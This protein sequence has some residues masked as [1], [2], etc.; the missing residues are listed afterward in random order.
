MI[1]KAIEQ[2]LRE[3]WNDN[4]ISQSK[5]KLYLQGYDY[6][7]EN[8]NK[9]P[10]SDKYFDEPKIHFII[11]SAVDMAL[12]S[13]AEV[14]NNSYYFSALTKKPS[15][16]E[17]SIIK[18]VYDKVVAKII[19]EFQATQPIEKV[20]DD[21]NCEEDEITAVINSVTEIV[22]EEIFPET[23]S[24]IVPPTTLGNLLDHKDLLTESIEFHKYRGDSNWGMDAKIKAFDTPLTVRY[25]QELNGSAGRQILSLEDKSLIEK[26]VNKFQTSS[27]TGILFGNN[28]PNDYDI[29][30][31]VPIY[32]SINNIR[33]KG[34]IDIVAVDHTNKRI[35]LYDIKTMAD[36]VIQFPYDYRKRNY[37]LQA[38]FY[39]YLATK[40]NTSS[41][42]ANYLPS[43]KLLNIDSYTINEFRFAVVSKLFP[44]SNPCVFEVSKVDLLR[45]IA[46]KNTSYSVSTDDSGVLY[47]HKYPSVPSIEQ[48]IFNLNSA[49]KNNKD[50]R[51]ASN[52]VNISNFI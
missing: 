1:Y 19:A 37:G 46:G 18:Y 15:D 22:E 45:T 43:N 3:Y 44:D 36:S 23:V 16:T 4:G 32:L 27:S 48:L 40:V 33:I 52:V 30:Y 26:I 7:L 47:E 38:A 17:I 14:F 49:I 12:T 50:P 2:K 10:L 8:I 11:G 41:W 28:T 39:Y 29:I 25:W 35:Y 5:I 21:T 42:L 31:Q 9:L 34:L 51:L 13:E 24:E 20:E 6:Y